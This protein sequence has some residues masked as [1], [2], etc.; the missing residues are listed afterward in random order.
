MMQF[1]HKPLKKVRGLQE[2]KLMGSGKDGF[3]PFADWSVYVLLQIWENEEVANSF[4][5][6]SQLI[7]RYLKKSEKRYTLFLKN[8]KSR[9][10]WSGKNPFIESKTIST[11][12]PFV[13]VI[14]RAT[15]KI[16]FLHKFWKYV[17]TSQ[18]P[19][20]HNN[21]LIYTKGIGEVPFLQ[22]AT[23]SIWKDKDS[24]MQFAYG[25]K[26]HSRAIAKTKE[27]KW[28]SEELFSRF[29]PYKSIGSWNGI[30][31]LPF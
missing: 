30:D 10:Y 28:Y 1:A 24:L 2:Y 16:R 3:N 6:T 11:D 7:E 22:M 8:T 12:N 20:A 14:T 15:I 23:F 21:G 25:S 5:D 17:P 4:F 26:E 9:G 27:L 18:R 31:Y 29:Q 13:A 19:L